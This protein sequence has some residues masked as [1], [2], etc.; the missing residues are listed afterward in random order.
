MKFYIP[1][2]V[3]SVIFSFRAEAEH[4]V[5]GEI[6]Y[7]CMGDNQYLIRLKI[8]RDCNSSGAEFDPNANM[9]IYNGNVLFQ[10]TSWNG[11]DDFDIPI[12]ASGP[13]YVNP[14]DLCLEMGVYERVMT[15]PPS[16]TGYTIVH[17]RC[18]RGA[19]ILNLSNPDTQGN[20]YFITIPPNDTECNSSAEFSDLPPA[21][22]CVNEPLSFDHS[23]TETDG[24]ELVYELCTPFHGGSQF[25]PAPNPA[26][27]PPYVSVSWAPGFSPT[28]PIISDTP[29][30]IDS[31]TGLLEGTPTQ[32]GQYVV[33]ICVSEYRDGELLST[34][35]RDFQIYVIP[36]STAITSVPGIASGDDGGCNGLDLQFTN[37]SFNA[38]DFLWDFGVASDP[39][40]VSTEFEP[41]YTYNDTGV[42]EVLLIANPG[43]ICADSSYVQVSAFPPVEVSIDSSG[44]V[45]ENG[46]YWS[47]ESS[48][49]F[50]PGV[51]EINW[52][53]GEGAT[54]ANGNSMTPSGVQYDS[55]GQKTVTLQV[56]QFGC[57]D[58]TSVNISVAEPV[59]ADIEPQTAFCEGLTL[60]LNSASENAE[61]FA[62]YFNDTEL[63]EIANSANLAYT[64]SEP[65][66]YEVMHVATAMNAC[67][68][69]AYQTFE[70]YPL[71]DPFFEIP[72][73]E[74]FEGNSF[75]FEAAGEFDTDADFSWDFGTHASP[76][77]SVTQNPPPVSYDSTGAFPV[78]LTVSQGICE[79]SHT[80]TV[81]VHPY[82]MAEFSATVS[83]G[84]APFKVSFN[85]ESI[86]GSPM[87]YN[88]DFGDGSSSNGAN[89]VH[90]YTEPGVY[91]VSLRVATF[92]GCVG[93]SERLRTDYITVLESPHAEFSFSPQEL[94]IF[95][96]EVEFLDQS[97]GGISCYYI[98]EDSTILEG[99]D[100]EYFF[101]EAGEHTVTQVVTNE[102]GC[103]H[104]AT[105][106]IEVLGH[107]FHAPN[108]FSP[109][110]D[111]IND[112]FKPIV[113]GASKYHLRVINRT[114]E[115]M[116][117]TT[118]IDEGW[119]GGGPNNTHY[120]QS[121]TFI[122]IARVTDMRGFNYDYQGHITIVR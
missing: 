22:I 32:Q 73:V 47:F 103:Q 92:S 65:G 20:T 78:T 30:T 113:L 54:P 36:C 98:T 56:D 26:T 69:T 37:N 102:E 41:E 97:E 1:L 80:A 33:G 95:N 24:D 11:F 115:V 107:L 31:N 62:W 104:S 50:D 120:L 23:A 46:Q 105:G 112:L 18:C 28:D 81:Q 16:P 85:D 8:Y 75:N 60:S 10:N 34:T 101:E 6:S 109:D 52:D 89:P 17:Q 106:T 55:P 4:L 70:A 59:I 79:D 3:L 116:F 29:F 117:E 91:S 42:Y 76:S 99:C 39:T 57:T 35:R 94:D 5:G 49:T 40:A 27:P 7:E 77:S 25:A 72:A 51:S 119:N 114:G 44:F 71:L 14:P 110:G 9:T 48:G 121:N 43:E 74:C 66:E 21:T 100:I 67:P 86:A 53:F 118:H 2:V 68:D 13:C 82:P 64:F 88:W 108:A 96:P 61:Q 45:C 15:L 84:C 122:Y 58:E 63:T 38:D 83:E 93:E 111:G 87:V 12:V 90:E 19:S